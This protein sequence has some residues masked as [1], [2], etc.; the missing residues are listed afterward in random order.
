MEAMNLR[1]RSEWSDAVAA[2]IRAQRARAKLTQAEVIERSGLGAS[3][4]VRIEQG[5]RVPD[6]TQLWRIC[7]AL[8]VPPSELVARAEQA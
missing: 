8:G 6:V 2:E 5:K 7:Q 1:E 3:T 4:Y